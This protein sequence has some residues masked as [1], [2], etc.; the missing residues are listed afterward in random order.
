MFQWLVIQKLNL[1]GPIS[2]PFFSHS[3][4]FILRGSSISTQIIL[5][6]QKYT[7]C[8][9]VFK[10]FCSQKQ[11]IILKSLPLHQ[12]SCKYRGK[13]FFIR[14]SAYVHGQHQTKAHIS[15][16]Q[17][18]PQD[19]R[20]SNI[21]LILGRVFPQLISRSLLASNPST[22]KNWIQKNA[23]AYSDTSQ[24]ATRRSPGI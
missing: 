20:G 19:L 3:T 1:K 14:I 2:N 6:K 17:A 22:A 18:A 23:G 11:D 8:N 9:L 12:N 21:S 24:L 13:L 10:C 5:E 16:D 4:F 15:C 7:S